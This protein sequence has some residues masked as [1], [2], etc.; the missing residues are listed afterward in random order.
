M[1]SNDRVPLSVSNATSDGK[2]TEQAM[3]GPGGH[4]EKKRNTA[5]KCELECSSTVGWSRFGTATR[6]CS[7]N[8]TT[9]SYLQGHRWGFN[10]GNPKLKD[11]D[12]HFVSQSLNSLAAAAATAPAPAD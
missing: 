1:N 8:A 11:S 3:T 9:S 7:E 5:D 6:T 4:I 12:Y 2:E 10:E